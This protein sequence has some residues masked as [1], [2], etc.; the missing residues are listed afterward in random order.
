VVLANLE[1]PKCL[2][3]GEKCCT[4]A[5]VNVAIVPLLHPK[6]GNSPEN[7][8]LSDILLKFATKMILLKK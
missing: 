8:E 7:L 6:E 2:E 1:R 3:S 5:D 4:F